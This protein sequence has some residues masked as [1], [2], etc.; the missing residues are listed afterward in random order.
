MAEPRG[1]QEIGARAVEELAQLLGAPAERVTGM[2]KVDHGW[3]ANI[4]VREMARVPETTDVMADYEVDLTSTGAVVGFR[5][6][7][8]YLRAEVEAH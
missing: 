1:I 8:R 3:S 5:R 7:R 2:R 6:I 4:E